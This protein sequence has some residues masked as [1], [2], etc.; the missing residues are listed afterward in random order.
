MCSRCEA[1]R[2]RTP[3][4]SWEGVQ[5]SYNDKMFA[6]S[7]LEVRPGNAVSLIETD[8]NVEFAPPL[9]YVEPEPVGA[10]GVSC[11]SGGE[12]LRSDHSLPW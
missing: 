7:V 8:M 1:V 3:R 12:W 6:F 10:K 4:L 2:A 9:D 11:A 5:F